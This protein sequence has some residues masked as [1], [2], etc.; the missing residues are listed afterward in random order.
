MY[1][2]KCGKENKDTSKFCKACGAP[3]EPIDTVI[4]EKPVSVE[5]EI[6]ETQ[7]V[8]EANDGE[9]K[10]NPSKVT[11]KAKTKNNISSKEAAER[12]KEDRITVH[13]GEFTIVKPGEKVLSPKEKLQ[14]MKEELLAKEQEQQIAKD[15]PTETVAE[16]RVNQSEKSEL[17]EKAAELS[18][19]D[20]AKVDDL[21]KQAH[22]L[23]RGVD[24]PVDID[25]AYE[26]YKSVLDI[27][28]DN[29]EALN[30]I[31]KICFDDDIDES[32]AFNCAIKSAKKG[33]AAGMFWLATFYA[34][35]FGCQE[36]IEEAINW[37][38]LSTES[39]YNRSAVTL[40]DYIDGNEYQ[41]YMASLAEQGND[42]A[43]VALFD[44]YMY[45]ENINEERALF[46]LKQG[47]DNNSPDAIGLYASILEF[48]SETVQADL[49]KAKQLWEKAAA[50]EDEH[51]LF[52]MG[53][54]YWHGE[55]GYPE[56]Y[57]IAQRYYEKVIDKG[58]LYY[59][60]AASD[61]GILLCERGTDD[62]RAVSL[63]T[64]AALEGNAVACSQLGSIYDLGV[65]GV[66][67]DLE[68]SIKFYE[69]AADLGLVSAMYTLGYT[70]LNG[71]NGRMPIDTMKGVKWLCE[72]AENGHGLA[73]EEIGDYYYN[74]Q[75]V[76]KDLKKARHYYEIAAKEG[77]T[78]AMFA[79]GVMNEEGEGG[80]KL[81]KA[82]EYWYKK[83]DESGADD[84]GIGKCNL[85]RLYLYKMGRYS[86]ALPMFVSAAQLGNDE[87][88]YYTGVCYY[89]GWGTP[90][91]MHTA[92]Y[93][94]NLSVQ[95]G[96]AAAQN[97]LSIIRQLI[98]ENGNNYSQ[99][100]Y[101]PIQHDD[102]GQQIIQKTTKEIGKGEKKQK[103]NKPPK[104]YTYKEPQIEPKQAGKIVGFTIA[105]FVIGMFVSFVIHTVSSDMNF[106]I[107]LLISYAFST[108]PLSIIRLK[109]LRAKGNKAEFGAAGGYL[110]GGGSNGNGCAVAGGFLIGRWLVNLIVGMV[111]LPYWFILSIVSLV[112]N[113]NNKK[114]GE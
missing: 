63:L 55:K 38:K 9:K 61:L 97:D 107:A 85:G 110:L 31:S 45:G 36:N 21:L 34:E 3:L 69:R 112:R 23:Q 93:W 109:G 39:G 17:K 99:E 51:A 98:S 40:N 84:S 47:V 48:G 70:Y 46:Y 33:N 111:T 52:R 4:E 108:L 11:V 102:S 86:E 89:S 78:K 43:A 56:D 76:E 14:K 15:K 7:K 10:L 50:M 113:S 41:R 68:K 103:T 12:A 13:K 16:E 75:F 83:L 2:T 54:F 32:F 25:T 44:Y 80:P 8:V 71:A 65:H 77:M 57:S 22:C 79:L 64:E 104:I 62:K 18:K 100:P 106:G 91:N 1:C 82:A 29:V 53:S 59:A 27:D 72:A 5:S 94:L 95:K 60:S 58:D 87:A 20:N 101:P 96:N 74:G 28:A 6:D 90:V 67:A 66:E 105:F 42:V 37:F 49:T 30:C 35:G 81:F 88:M 73:A 26:L 19:E 114:I 92:E 24:C